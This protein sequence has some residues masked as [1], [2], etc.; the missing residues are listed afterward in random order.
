MG[1]N[2]EESAESAAAR[3]V[4]DAHYAKRS[5]IHDPD[6]TAVQ[7]QPGGLEPHSIRMILQLSAF[8]V[9][10]REIA[11]Q[12]K[13]KGSIIKA[14]V[15][16]PSAQAEILR[17]QKQLFEK[18]FKQMFMRL[19]PTA[20][21]TTFNLMTS[22]KVKDNVRLQAADILMDRAL[23]KPKQVIEETHGGLAEVLEK[24]NGTNNESNSQNESIEAEFERIAKASAQTAEDNVEFAERLEEAQEA[25]FHGGEAIKEAEINPYADEE[26]D[27]EIDEID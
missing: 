7:A 15:K 11:K 4:I 18:D 17:L 26:N 2:T 14:I 1:T 24:L 27:Q 22:K 12:T 5:E 13:I 3:H 25:G 21:H 20:V 23:G 16:S 19:L 10:P 8:G 6:S 9:T